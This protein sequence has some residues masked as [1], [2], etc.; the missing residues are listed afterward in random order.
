MKKRV[1]KF[2]KLGAIQRN[3]FCRQIKENFVPAEEYART[4]AGGVGEI[5]SVDSFVFFE[6]DAPEPRKFSA[7]KH[8][9]EY[10]MAKK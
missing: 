7:M 4:V 6:G 1:R 8:G 3:R 9:I 5:G 2:N 10:V